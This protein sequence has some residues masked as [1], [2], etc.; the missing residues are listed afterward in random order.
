MSNA[1]ANEHQDNYFDAEEARVAEMCSRDTWLT[2]HATAQGFAEEQSNHS[3]CAF[4]FSGDHL[5]TFA[6]RETTPDG[7]P[8]EEVRRERIHTASHVNV[9][10]HPGVRAA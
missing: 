1:F 5:G 2:L 7:D 10:S 4:P 9:W 8:G 6:H 3:L